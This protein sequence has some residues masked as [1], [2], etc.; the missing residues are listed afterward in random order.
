M[1]N[2]LTVQ[3]SRGEY[4]QRDCETM[5]FKFKDKFTLKPKPDTLK[6]TL[7]TPQFDY[8]TYESKRGFLN[9]EFWKANILLG[10]P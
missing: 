10:S 2:H 7:G 4:S 6:L 8:E 5:K 9:K 1:V 3:Y